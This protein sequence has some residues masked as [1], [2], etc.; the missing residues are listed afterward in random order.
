MALWKLAEMYL[1]PNSTGES[2]SLAVFELEAIDRAR[3]EADDD[4]SR[5]MVVRRL[6]TLAEELYGYRER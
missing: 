3:L 6:Q 4:M 1:M 5:E 2:L